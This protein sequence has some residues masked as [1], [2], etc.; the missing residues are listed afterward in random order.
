M[1]TITLTRRIKARPSIVFEALTTAGG[2]TA[3]WGP[4]DLPVVS[5]EADARVGGT[6]RVRF[7][8]IDGREHEAHGTYLEL[9]PP[10]RIVMTYAYALGGEF[11]ELG[12]TSRVEFELVAFAGGTDLTF[13]HTDLA[14]EVSAQSHAYGWTGALDKLVRKM[15]LVGAPPNVNNGEQRQ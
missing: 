12:R 1:S 8:S 6:Y 11:D 4:H 7:R 14:S 15:E 13:T 10:R 5:A 3:W 2:M 9:V